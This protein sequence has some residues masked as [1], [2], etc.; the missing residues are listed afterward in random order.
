MKRK[1]TILT[2]QNENILMTFLIENL[3]GQ[4]KNNVKSLLS[5]E[6]V[7][8]N[9]T[10]TRQFNH[11][12]KKGDSVSINWTKSRDIKS[13]KN[14]KSIKILF[15]DDHLIAI[16]KESGVLSMAADNVPG[17]TAYNMLKD[18]VKSVDPKN[19]I[20]IVH[21]LDKDTSGVMIFAKSEKIQ[22]ALQENWNDT[23]LER[24]YLALVDGIV[25]TPSGKIESYLKENKAL[26]TYS[27]K[28]E[29]EGGKLAITNYKVL[30]SGRGISLVELEL[31]TGRK[32]QIRVHMKEMGHPILGDRKYDSV[33]NPIN[34]LALHAHT[35]KFKHPATGNIVE[36]IS[37]MPDSF[38]RI[39]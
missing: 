23:I 1:N 38:N 34:R 11:P 17:S 19:K 32:N 15:E 24:K 2:V 37:P 6:Q 25:R 33:N 9:E 31:E 8:V 22:N 14:L 27:V 18:H 5:N 3:L 29:T 36:Y 26:V 4:S 16:E 13:S 12:L 35:L 20:F 10:M 39:K 28:S 7:F 21:R 30:K